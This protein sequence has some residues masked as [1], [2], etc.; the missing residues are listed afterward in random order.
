MKNK[1]HTILAVT[2]LGGLLLLCLAG[3]QENPSTQPTQNGDSMGGDSMTIIGG[4]ETDSGLQEGSFEKSN[5]M[6]QITSNA[7]EL[8]GSRTLD[9]EFPE[10]ETYP[11]QGDAEAT[12][13][14]WHP[15]VW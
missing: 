10:E 9:I 11:D 8:G 15:G 4:E 2:L 12:E 1:L 5:Q 3:C 13:P 6:N 7:K 14:Q